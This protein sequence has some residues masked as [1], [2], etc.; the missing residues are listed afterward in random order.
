[1]TPGVA[2]PRARL[3]SS[4]AVAS[5]ELASTFQLDVAADISDL[6]N[7]YLISFIYRGK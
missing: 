7:E 4:A 1:M 6:D 3:A 2:V 5:S